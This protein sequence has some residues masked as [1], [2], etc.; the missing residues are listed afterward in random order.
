M[1]IEMDTIITLAVYIP[2]FAFIAYM[3][4]THKG[5]K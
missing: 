1:Y 4:I 3:T 2:L 5:E